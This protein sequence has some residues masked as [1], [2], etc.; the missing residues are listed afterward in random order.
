MENAGLK[1]AILF[2]IAS[3]CILL[4]M[5]CDTK[6]DCVYYRCNDEYVPVCSAKGCTCVPDQE[7]TLL[8]CTS[9]KDCASLC[10][11][12]CTVKLCMSGV[13]FCN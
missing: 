4:S 5:A 1:M 3:Q 11:P 12:K 13:C 8:H 6:E 7:N 2:L 9:D 10:P